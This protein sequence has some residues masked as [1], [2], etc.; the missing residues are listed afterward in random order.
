MKGFGLLVD[1]FPFLVDVV[2]D[3]VEE[4]MPRRVSLSKE[5]LEVG[6]H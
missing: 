3:L 5:A 1:E 4:Q 2:L 6:K